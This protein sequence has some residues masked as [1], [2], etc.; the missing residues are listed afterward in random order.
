MENR[1]CNTRNSKWTNAQKK[2]TKKNKKK[3]LKWICHTI[4]HQGLSIV[5]RTSGEI[6][7]SRIT[8]AEFQIRSPK[9]VSAD[10]LLSNQLYV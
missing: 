2:K 4:G 3:R 10:I 5:Q 9:G 1:I 6:T 8:H 7:E